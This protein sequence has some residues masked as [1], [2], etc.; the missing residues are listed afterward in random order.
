[1]CSLQMIMEN[2]L[3]MCWTSNLDRFLNGAIA[4]QGDDA[5]TDE[6]DGFVSGSE[7]EEYGWFGIHQKVLNYY[8]A[9]HL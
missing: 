5:T 8:G 9:S 3:A 1:M 7:F 6:L 4:A 2:G